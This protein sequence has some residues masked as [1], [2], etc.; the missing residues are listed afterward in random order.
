MLQELIE[1]I[2]DSY[3]S[4]VI[5]ESTAIDKKKIMCIMIRYFSKSKQKVITSFYKLVLVESGEAAALYDAFTNNIKDSGL[6]LNNLIGIGV[7]GANAMVGAHN[8]LASRL[9]AL[10]PHLVVVKCVC[11]SL[12]L[13]AEEAF[14]CLP[15]HI[16]FLIRVLQLV[17]DEQ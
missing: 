2:G 17:F 4:A 8:S 9:T 10:I 13:A 14:K 12:H 5:D 16:D 6:N 1:D 3:Y 15:K 11:H 7:D